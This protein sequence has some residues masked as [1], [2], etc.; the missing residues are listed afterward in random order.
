MFESD[1][2]TGLISMILFYLTYCC[3]VCKTSGK[4]FIH[5]LYFHQKFHHNSGQKR[6][7]YMYGL[8]V[9]FSLGIHYF[10]FMAVMST[11]ENRESHIKLQESTGCYQ[12]AQASVHFNICW[13]QLSRTAGLEETSEAQLSLVCVSREY[14][15]DFS[16]GEIKMNLSKFLTHFASPSD[17]RK[18]KFT[19][20]ITCYMANIWAKTG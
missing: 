7:N 3:C 4:D 14:P 16:A 9:Y 6:K 2:E 18:S 12:T 1:R 19:V 20:S 10:F 15:D 5:S 13:A 8:L 11:A 17:R